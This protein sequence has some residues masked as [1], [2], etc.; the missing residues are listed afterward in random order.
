MGKVH[1]PEGRS[2]LC[3]EGEARFLRSLKAVDCHTCLVIL[4]LNNRERKMAE[5]AQEEINRILTMRKQKQV[6][7]IKRKERLR[8]GVSAHD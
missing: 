7:R 4:R 5:R 8:G 1:M 6:A 3:G 2:T